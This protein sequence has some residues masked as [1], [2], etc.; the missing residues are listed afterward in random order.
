MSKYKI[1]LIGAH[2]DD[3]DL[4]GGGF[5]ALHLA[6]G[7]E[8]KFVSL[9]DGSRGH[10]EM[11]CEETRARR[12]A[13]TQALAAKMGLSYD[14]WDVPDGE[15]MPTLENRKRL[16]REIRAFAPDLILTH[17]SCDYHPDHRNAAILVQDASYLLIVPNFC[18][19]VKALSKTPVIAYYADGFAYPPFRPDFVVP[20]DSVIEKKF[21]MMHCHKSQFYEWLPYSKGFLAEVPAGDAER[22]E[23]LHTPRYDKESIARARAGD[24]RF[25]NGECRFAI[26]A[27]RFRERLIEELGA[28]VGEKVRF[29]EA[30]MIS[31][32]S[33]KRPKDEMKALFC[34]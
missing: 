21:E 11:T 29:A 2:P 16:V 33:G 15:L 25:Y 19:E 18:T 13:E 20:I 8:V 12:F 22:F 4:C 17:R 7:A 23:W 28:D 32:Y 9:T 14:V 10:H 1:M 24:K 30:F 6:R 26:P 5:A 27:E 34:L 31:E 3:H